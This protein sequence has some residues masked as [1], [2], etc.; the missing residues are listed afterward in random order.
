VV[1]RLVVK[2]RVGCHL[3]YSRAPSI[4]FWRPELFRE[5]KT[6]RNVE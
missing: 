4:T 5:R 3:L 6:Y 2:R 1:K